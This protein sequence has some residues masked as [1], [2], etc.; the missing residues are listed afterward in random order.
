MDP[1]LINLEE[2]DPYMVKCPSVCSILLRVEFGPFLGKMPLFLVYDEG[3]K[4]YPYLNNHLFSVPAGGWSPAPGQS[5][6]A[7]SPLR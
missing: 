3:L 2:I 6:H 4:L 1:S 5:D 7:V